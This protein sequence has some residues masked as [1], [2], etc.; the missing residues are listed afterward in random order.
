M[1][2]S[3]KEIV[4]VSLETGSLPAMAEKALRITGLLGAMAEH[5][6]LTNRFAV[7]GG[8]AL[9]LF[10]L[11]LPRLPVDIRLNYT[12]EPGREEMLE[13]RPGVEGALKTVFDGEGYVLKKQAAGYAGGRW[14]LGYTGFDGRPGALE[15]DL[16]FLLRRPLWN[17]VKLDSRRLGLCRARSIP[18]AGLEELA[19][20]KLCV[21]FSRQKARDLFDSAQVLTMD[22]VDCGKLRLAFVVYGAMRR[23]DWRRVSVNDI[24]FDPEEIGG[25]LAPLLRRTDNEALGNRREYGQSLFSEVKANLCKVL[26]LHSNEIQFLDALLDKGE[27]AAGL[28]TGD[29][30]LQQA[31]GSHPA[32]LWKARKARKYKTRL[33]DGA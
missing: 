22:G 26:P 5:P 12:G 3:R 29:K 18:V 32:L 23:R 30:A 17:P 25:A 21:L 16:N 20:E 8:T 19:G 1:R 33:K 13:A 31:I 15:V 7:K 14:R 28:L 11:D 6:S 4:R 9:N 24:D 2:P 27:I 10:Y